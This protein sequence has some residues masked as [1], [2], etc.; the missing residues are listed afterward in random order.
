MTG[1]T[2]VKLY[3]RETVCRDRKGRP[4]RWSGQVQVLRNGRGGDVWV[5]GAGMGRRPW[6]RRSPLAGGDLGHRGVGPPPPLISP[7]TRPWDV[8]MSQGH[9]GC[10]RVQPQEMGAHPHARHAPCQ[11]DLCSSQLRAQ[12]AP[13]TSSPVRGAWEKHLFSLKKMEKPH[14]TSAVI[15]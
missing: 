2:G 13:L 12:R 15:S 7:G 4:R 3:V 14:L 11:S 5:P 6:K 8:L 10:P 1:G 9:M